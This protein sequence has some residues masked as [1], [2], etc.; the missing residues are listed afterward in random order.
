LVPGVTVTKA[1]PICTPLTE[2]GIPVLP[3]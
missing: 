2:I 3:S 1:T